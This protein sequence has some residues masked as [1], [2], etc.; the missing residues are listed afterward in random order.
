MKHLWKSKCKSKYIIIIQEI[1][2][3]VIEKLKIST[4]WAEQPVFTICPA[5]A[6]G[7]KAKLLNKKYGKNVTSILN[8]DLP[9]DL[10]GSKEFY[11]EI[12][13]NISEFIKFISFKT[14]DH[15]PNLPEKNVHVTKFDID[16]DG[17][18]GSDGISYK[19]DDHFEETYWANFGNCF[20]LKIIPKFKSLIVRRYVFQIAIYKSV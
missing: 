3:I 16:H 1:L 12:T 13:Y 5:Y 18:K 6:R 10:E 2:Y 14:K 20:K 17:I 9:K 7:F 4:K 15:L 19:H 8:F 11:E